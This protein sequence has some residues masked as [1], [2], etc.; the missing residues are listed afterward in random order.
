MLGALRGHILPIDDLITI[1]KGY[2]CPLLEC[3]VP[4]WNEVITKR[5]QNQL[6][7][8]RRCVLKLIS[9]TENGVYAGALNSVTLG[10]TGVDLCAFNLPET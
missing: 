4:D 3:V 9:G 7:K 8:V 5:Q 1:Y 10:L 6:G 2:L